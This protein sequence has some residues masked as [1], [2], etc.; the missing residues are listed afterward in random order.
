MHNKTISYNT[1]SYNTGKAFLYALPAYLLITLLLIS[2]ARLLM[3]PKLGVVAWI[4]LSV[5]PFVFQK[6]IKLLFTRKIILNFDDKNFKISEFG[7]QD[8]ELKNEFNYRWEDIKSY[9]CYF[10]ASSVTYI[11]LYLRD[12]SSKNL[13]FNDKDQNSAVVE[14]SVFSL[15]YYFVSQYNINKDPDDKIVFKPGFFT[16][17]NGL[18]LI[19]SLLILAIVL[20]ITHFIVHPK[21]AMMSLMALFII[22]GLFGKR[23][24]DIMFKDKLE[25]LEPI[26]IF[27]I[28][29]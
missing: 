8:D 3:M 25:N 9:R 12:G 19:V 2:V 15:F 17:S 26:N 24:K 11:T 16:T 6:K 29:A 23:K 28:D 27:I 22:L 10:S 18:A 1:K 20:I 7:L 4:V 13:S 5:I 21:S 14:E